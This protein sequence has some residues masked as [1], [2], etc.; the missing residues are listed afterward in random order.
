MADL[1]THVLVAYALLT[2]A[3]WWLDWLTARWIVIGT[4]GA[5]VPDLTR[6]DLL[7]DADTVG[8]LLGVPFTWAHLST[9]G[10]VLLVCAVITVLFER[11]WWRRVFGLLVAGG[12]SSLV[13]DGLRVYAD[14]RAGQWLFPFLPT[15]RPPTPGLYVSSDP[16]VL[17]VAVVVTA[18]VIGVDRSR[19]DRP[20]S[21][22]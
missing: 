3:S 13:L 8:G 12:L 21:A 14:G 20:A 4:G 1:L 18:L 10:G 11:D 22:K 15:Y 5:I 9:L 2:V 19:D 16:L 6:L 17:V 7:V